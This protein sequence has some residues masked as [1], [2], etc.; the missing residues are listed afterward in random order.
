MPTPS[1]SLE[2]AV[3]TISPALTNQST[4]PPTI[5]VNA[6]VSPPADEPIDI[7]TP[8]SPGGTLPQNIDGINVSG[9]TIDELFQVYVDSLALITPI[10]IDMS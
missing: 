1:I 8:I 5:P 4:S 2:T 3:N 7:K 6:I 9:A 10:S